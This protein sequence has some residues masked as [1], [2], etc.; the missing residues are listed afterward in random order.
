MGKCDHMGGHGSDSVDSYSTWAHDMAFTQKCGCKKRVKAV[1]SY[2]ASD[3]TLATDHTGGSLEIHFGLNNQSVATAGSDSY[4][5]S[6]T[7][8][9]GTTC[10]TGCHVHYQMALDRLNL[11]E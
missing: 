11:S 3:K 5:G 4:R 8:D 6:T 2:I 10:D 9:I 7:K 1:H